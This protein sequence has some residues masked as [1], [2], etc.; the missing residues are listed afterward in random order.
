M[1]ICTTN[2]HLED[3]AY[4]AFQ[5]ACNL[6]EEF[7]YL[8]IYLMDKDGLDSVDEIKE[9][10]ISIDSKW[11]PCT[12]IALRICTEMK[13]SAQVT[14]CELSQ[15]GIGCQQILCDSEGNISSYTTYSADTPTTLSELRYAMSREP[16]FMR[17]ISWMEDTLT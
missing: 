14:Y 15:L 16:L 13:I 17:L 11:T 4:A 8:V 6:R 9:G 1:A 12:D 10:Y 7:P 5:L 3:N 2:I